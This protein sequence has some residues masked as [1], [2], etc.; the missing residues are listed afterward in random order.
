MM[1]SICLQVSTFLCLKFFF[2]DIG[3]HTAVSPSIGQEWRAANA[4]QMGPGQSP[5]RPAHLV[6]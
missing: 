2:A 6:F 5:A 3:E 1:S 4:A